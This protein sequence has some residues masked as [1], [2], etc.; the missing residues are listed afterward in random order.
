TTASRGEISVPAALPAPPVHHPQ[1][2][3]VPARTPVPGRQ[4]SGPPRGPDRRQPPGTRLE[5]AL[6]RRRGLR[7]RRRDPARRHLH[8]GPAVRRP[9]PGPRGLKTARPDRG[10]RDRRPPPERCLPHNR[11]VTSK[12]E[13]RLPADN[14]P[15]KQADGLLHLATDRYAAP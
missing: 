3:P 7:R 6:Q 4:R 1:W 8:P 11:G 13:P 15:D 12:E 5:P 10:V 2:Q 9:R 14:L